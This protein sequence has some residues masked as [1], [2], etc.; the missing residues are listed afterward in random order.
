MTRAES[1]IA[2]REAL[3]QLADQHFFDLMRL[4]LGAVK[5]PFNKQKLVEALSALL[6]RHETQ[7]RMIA[8]LD[9]LDILVLSAIRELTVPTQGRIIDLFRGEYSFA[10]LYERILNLEERL[11]IYRRGGTG[12]RVY[13]INPYLE[14]GVAQQTGRSVLVSPERA[15]EEF[16]HLPAIDSLALAGLFSFFLNS[17]DAVKNDGTF[18]KRTYDSFIASF[19]LCAASTGCLDSLLA[20]IQNIGLVNRREGVLVPD[21]SRWKVFSLLSP[22]DQR[23]YLAAA[24]MGRAPRERIRAR[25]LGILELVSSLEHGAAYRRETVSRLADLIAERD[26]S[27]G[28]ARPG[29]R[30]AA[31]L[32]NVP[33][34]SPDGQP[35]GTAAIE[36]SGRDDTHSPI[37]MAAAALAFGFLTEIDGEYAANVAA[38]TDECVPLSFVVSPTFT[39]TVMPGSSLTDLLT[40]ARFLEIETVQ[41]AGQFLLTR[42]SVRAAFDQGMSADDVISA[43][44]SGSPHEVPGNVRF[45]VE[46][47]YRSWSS[48]SLYR[49][50]VLRVDESRRISFENSAAIASILGT[51]LAPGVWLLDAESEDEIAAA[52]TEAGIETA[53]TLSIPALSHGSP[54]FQALSFTPRT[55]RSMSEQ[56]P[57][58]KPD[59]VVS[60]QNHAANSGVAQSEAIA[61]HKQTLI[62]T[63]DMMTLDEDARESLVSR[64]D[65]RIVLFPEQL[66]PSSVK[67]D[68]VEARGM[69]FLGKVRIV[70]YAIA[71][72]SLVEISLDDPEGPRLILGRPLTTEKRNGDV[73]AKLALEGDGVVETI[74]IGRALLVRRI[75][76][77]IFSE[78]PPGRG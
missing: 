25:A 44:E 9:R 64:I 73:L 60:D 33:A 23:A 41:T 74:S 66:D 50:F 65:R 61:R 70:E 26:I 58:Q 47:W 52:F 28:V 57:A 1:V 39:V 37:D 69:D 51:H 6:R 10:E 19:P 49:G 75:R 11:V 27:R 8:L 67:I 14:D 53:P 62:D 45:S 68:K 35:G 22:T 7:E 54:P 30:L 29:S 55:T 13:A 16:T 18:R 36:S 46:D 17:A 2:W 56:T 78:L 3:V 4:Y 63:L 32:R 59:P 12:E 31:I 5:T 42:K 40:L 77:S 48:V 71:S 72:G 34:T 38:L 43:L 15:I 21:Y 20:A 76:G 24:A